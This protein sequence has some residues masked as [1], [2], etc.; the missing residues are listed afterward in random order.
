MNAAKRTAAVLEINSFR[1]R[2][3]SNEAIESVAQVLT[4]R[5]QPSNTEGV[6]KCPYCPNV[7]KNELGLKIHTAKTRACKAKAKAS[8]KQ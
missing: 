2:Q 6:V 3:T 4:T 7:C 1:P 8:A 5:A